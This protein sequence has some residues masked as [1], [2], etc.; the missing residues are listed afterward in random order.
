MEKL[1]LFSVPIFKFKFE[2]HNELK[3]TFV[4]YLADEKLYEKNT[5]RTTLYFTEPNLHKEKIFEPFTN[6]INNSVEKVFTEL[7]YVPS[8]NITGMW[9]TKHKKNG[10]HH[11]HQHYNSFIAGVYYLDGKNA[12]GTIFHSPYQISPIAPAKIK[13]EVI[14]LNRTYS[15]NFEEGTLVIFPAWLEHSTVSNG[16]SEHTRTI[17]SFN[18]MPVGKTNTDPFDRYNYQDIT[19]ADMMDNYD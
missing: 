12:S 4:D 6:F 11:R 2:Q 13:K 14:V 19:E 10:F 18:V 7:N 9:A 8:F 17:L 3:Q 1:H 5:R 15:S 16:D